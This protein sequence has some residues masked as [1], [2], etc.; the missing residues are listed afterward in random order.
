MHNHYATELFEGTI[1]YHKF[2]ETNWYAI[3]GTK[4]P[5]F[6]TLVS[7]IKNECSDLSDFK[8]Y[9]VGGTLENWMSWDID[10]LLI[11]KYNPT[12]IKS[13]ME[14][15]LRI[16]FDLHLYVDITFYEKLWAIH[17]YCKTGK[18]EE[19]IK[20]YQVSNHFVK[21][22]N[23]LNLDEWKLNAD[24]LYCKNSKFPMQKHINARKVGYIYHP[25]ILLD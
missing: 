11:G 19:E 25:P 2:K 4:H 22:G 18:P 13:V 20:A 7:R 3:G 8:L 21:D 12:K 23:K 16:S 24:G 5:L 6:K 10:L 17:E 1:E 15:I 9:V 14:D